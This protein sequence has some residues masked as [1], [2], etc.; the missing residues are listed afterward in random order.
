MFIALIL[1]P[2]NSFSWKHFSKK[3]V[4]LNTFKN[5]PH[6]AYFTYLSNNTQNTEDLIIF[7]I[8]DNYIIKYL[9]ITDCT[10]VMLL[11]SW[12]VAVEIITI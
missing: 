8:N 3:D 1:I 2:A 12:L 7:L 9:K 11:C 6:I 5:I 4:S 10:D